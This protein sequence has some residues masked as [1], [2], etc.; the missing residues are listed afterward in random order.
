MHTLDRARERYGVWL[1]RDDYE[2]MMQQIL[3]GR[4]RYLGPGDPSTSGLLYGVVARGVP[5]LVVY[6]L[7]RG[8]IVTCLEDRKGGLDEVDTERSAGADE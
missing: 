2:G 3:T 8:Y 4:A 6:C 1:N 7:T 5:L